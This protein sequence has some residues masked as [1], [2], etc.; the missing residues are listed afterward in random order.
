[1]WNSGSDQSQRWKSPL[2]GRRVY[3][4]TVQIEQFH[5]CYIEN[6]LIHD[7]GMATNVDLDQTG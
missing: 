6:G 1:M 5:L 2:P 3:L 4:F 7:K